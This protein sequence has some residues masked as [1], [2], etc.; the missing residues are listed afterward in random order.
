MILVNELYFYIACLYFDYFDKVNIAVWDTFLDTF[1]N[2]ET[3]L[4][5][6]RN[7]QFCLSVFGR[8]MGL[9]LKGFKTDDDSYHIFKEL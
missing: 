5:S 8:F 2:T 1:S 7:S 3:F 6:I 4:V 9:A